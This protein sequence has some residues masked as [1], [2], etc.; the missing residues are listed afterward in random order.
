MPLGDN[1]CIISKVLLPILT[2]CPVS[3][4]YKSRPKSEYRNPKSETISK[5]ECSKFKTKLDRHSGSSVLVICICFEFQ[6]SNFGFP[7]LWEIGQIWRILP[8]FQIAIFRD[9]TYE[10][11]HQL[12]YMCPCV[13]ANKAFSLL[14]QGKR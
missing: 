1:Y 3:E 7:R 5:F 13:T 2:I 11:R 4:R 10:T 8:E 9:R 12:Y 14:D 6:Y